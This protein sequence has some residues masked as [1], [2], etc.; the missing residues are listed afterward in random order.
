V[1]GRVQW[2]GRHTAA[3]P[4]LGR[5][6]WALLRK[7]SPPTGSPAAPALLLLQ[8]LHQG[9]P[10]QQLLAAHCHRQ[11]APHP[12]TP[13]ARC[14]CAHWLTSATPDDLLIWGLAGAARGGGCV[15][16]SAAHYHDHTLCGRMCCHLDTTCR[17]C[18][19]V[20]ASAQRPTPVFRIAR[21]AN[22]AVM[23]CPKQEAQPP[24]A[25]PSK[26][27]SPAAQ[28]PRPPAWPHK[29][30]TQATTG[31]RRLARRARRSKVLGAKKPKTPRQ[32]VAG[33]PR[34]RL[35]E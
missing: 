27:A 2:G 31:G 14:L 22:A 15:R 1:Q 9:C 5:R 8:Q 26:N 24:R 28:Q 30:A 13:R 20:G 32:Q 23:P 25:V 16:R 29:H 33:Q 21:Q 18:Y 7:H 34:T 11:T 12:T 3:G 17:A 35:P 4:A 10:A 19:S 6:L